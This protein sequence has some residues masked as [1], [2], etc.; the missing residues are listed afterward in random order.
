MC[1]IIMICTFDDYST[2]LEYQNFQKYSHL[3]VQVKD[4]HYFCPL[5]SAW[6]FILISCSTFFT[7]V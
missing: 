4:S 2:E 3:Q 1:F 6:I 7:L 5:K